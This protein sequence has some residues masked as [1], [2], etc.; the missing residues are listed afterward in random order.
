MR[1]T[2]RTTGIFQE[3]SMSNRRPQ[4]LL[5]LLG[6]L[7]ALVLLSLACAS[8]PEKRIEEQ[9]ALFDSYPADV[10]ATIRSGKVALGYDEDMVRMALGEPDETSTELRQDGEILTWG[11]TKSSPGVSIGLGGLGMGGGGVG[12]GGGVGVGSGPKKNYT[13]IVEFRAGKV[14]NV[15]SFDD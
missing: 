11:Y 3:E 7:A 10:Q 12:I 5:S 9:Q 6:G 8:T 14:S 2:I 13:A 15:R 1:S 4:P